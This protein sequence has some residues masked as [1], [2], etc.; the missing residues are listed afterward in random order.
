LLGPYPK[1][2]AEAFIRTAIDPD[3]RRLAR[4]TRREV[5]GQRRQ[6]EQSK[7]AAAVHATSD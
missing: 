7:E 4:R 1:D 3:D 6:S 5:R 2:H